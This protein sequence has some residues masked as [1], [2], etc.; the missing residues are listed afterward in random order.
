MK[1]LSRAEFLAL[2]GPVLYYKW[3]KDWSHPDQ[4]LKIKYRT[5]AGVDWVAQGIDPLW[6]TL[7]EKPEVPHH[8]TWLYIDG[9]DY[10]GPIKIDLDFPGRDGLFDPDDRYVVLES[11]DIVKVLGKVNECYQHALTTEK[12]KDRDTNNPIELPPGTGK[13]QE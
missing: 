1:V 7:P 3:Q 5:M 8:D 2:Q 10:K 12:L 11:D 6:V 9:T 4:E 13:T